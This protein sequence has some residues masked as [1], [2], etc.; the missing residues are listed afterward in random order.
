MVPGVWVEMEQM[1]LTTSGKVDRK[2]LP[3]P[4][5]GRR[6]Q[7]QEYVGPR[8]EVEEKLCAIWSQ[9]LGVERIGI[10]DNF[11]DLGGDSILATQAVSRIRKTGYFSLPLKSLF[12]KP[13]IA[14]L[15]REI[16]QLAAHLGGKS[17]LAMKPFPRS[18]KNLQELLSEVPG[19]SSRM[20]VLKNL[21]AKQD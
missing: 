10:H 16:E 9:V 6:E 1:P 13:T 18:K 4:D 21:K 11:F 14:N 7:A 8:N 12:Q 3:E 2:K 15:A 19:F 17:S 5:K 20:D